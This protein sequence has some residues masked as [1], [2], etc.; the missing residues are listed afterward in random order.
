MK[1]T[2][3]LSRDHVFNS[4]GDLRNPNCRSQ[5]PRVVQE[6]AMC[7]AHGFLKGVSRWL[8]SGHVVA[9]IR[10]WSCQC[11]LENTA[12][13]FQIQLIKVGSSKSHSNGTALVL[14]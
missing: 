6:E 8:L 10:I 5:P 1:A 3:C 4:V 2:H 9:D 14:P 12:K 11:P 7:N 13:Q